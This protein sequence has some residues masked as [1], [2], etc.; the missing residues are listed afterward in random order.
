MMGNLTKIQLRRGTQE[1]WETAKPV[2]A[3]GE[4]GVVIGGPLHGK[5]KIGYE[6]KTWDNLK[7]TDEDKLSK[8]SHDNTLAGNGTAENPLG[9][10]AGFTYYIDS[11]EKLV[12]CNI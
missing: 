6:N 7:Y 3:D 4:P 8:I 2:L 10:S 11:V 1:N 5:M 12:G 9:V